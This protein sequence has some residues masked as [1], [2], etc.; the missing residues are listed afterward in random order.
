MKFFSIFVSE[1]D[2]LSYY[3]FIYI[4]NNFNYKQGTQVIIMGMGFWK[5]EHFL[6][7][8]AKKGLK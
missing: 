7:F 5:K 3:L 2:Y 8:K 4:Y 6:H 1:I